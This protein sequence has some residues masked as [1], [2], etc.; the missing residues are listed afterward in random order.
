MEI[1]HII[2]IQE[3]LRNRGI[4]FDSKRVKLVRHIDHR[5]VKLIG[6][7]EYQDSLYSLYRS[8]PEVF[9]TYQNEQDTA[10]F[11]KVD[12]IVSF[13]GEE[14]STARFIGVYKKMGQEEKEGGRSLFDF[15]KVSGF[16]ILEEKVIID[17][18]DNA[19]S[20]HQW[21][22]NIKYVIRIDRGMS[23]GEI[24]VFHS[25]EDVMLSYTQLNAI[26]TKDNKE[27]RTKLEAVNCVYLIL[28][29]N[30]GKQYVGVT[31][32]GKK[33][34]GIG[35]WG[36]WKEYAE[37]GGHGN[38]KTLMDIWQKDNLYPSQYFQ[39]CILET[40]PLNVPDK[41]AIERESL[42]KEKFGTRKHGYNNN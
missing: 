21:W 22:D 13:I 33:S 20:W 29:K 42:Y 15:R 38:D 10:K 23:E 14:N 16:E 31:Y 27:W 41:V 7:K 32:R 19:I 6:N 36:R 1:Q 30:N 4:D 25:Y 34:S 8:Q 5:D 11:N 28:D 37:T 2:S 26:F 9:L 35:I 40:L 18:G 24:P 12:Y 17:W 39:W 3:L